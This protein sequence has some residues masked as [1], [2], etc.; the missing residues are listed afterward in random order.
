MP[1]RCADA[2]TGAKG[3]DQISAHD[4]FLAR[5]DRHV[6]LSSGRPSSRDDPNPNAPGA[7]GTR[8]VIRVAVRDRSQPSPFTTSR[9]N[10]KGA[11]GDS[12]GGLCFTPVVASGG[13]DS[14]PMPRPYTILPPSEAVYRLT[15]N[16]VR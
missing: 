12:T 2:R 13:I 3:A 4:P 15:P 8:R 9:T 1:S 11:A 6:G 5:A 10:T 7:S 14:T 16:A